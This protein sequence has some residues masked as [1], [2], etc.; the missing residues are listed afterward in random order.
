VNR[1]VFWVA[2]IIVMVIGAL[3]MPYGY[4]SL[5]RLV[6]CGCSV[7]FALRLHQREEVL[8]V[9]IFGFVAVLYNPII[10]VHLYEKA[11]WMVVNVI[12]AILFYLKRSDALRDGMPRD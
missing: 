10:P 7:Y 1:N 4:Y 3:P 6:V 12:T 8:F 2:P 11:I 5:L 9:W